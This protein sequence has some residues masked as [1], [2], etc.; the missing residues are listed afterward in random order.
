MFNPYGFRVGRR[1]LILAVITWALSVGDGLVPATS[2]AESLLLTRSA[3]AKS[4]PP[5]SKSAL[6]QA[7]RLLD[8]QEPEAA[9]TMLRRFLS[10]SPRAEDLDDAYLLMAGAMMG[11]KEYGE[12]GKYLTQLLSEFPKSELLPRAKVLLAQTHAQAGNLDLALPL[13]A[14]VR[15]HTDDLNTKREALRLSGDYFV[16]KKDYLRALQVW[17][18]ETRLETDEHPKEAE[19]RIKDLVTQTLDR[20]TLMRV[21]DIYARSFPGDLALMKLIE[22]QTATGEDHLVE[23]NTR[24]FLSRFPNHP[25]VPKASEILSTVKTKFQMYRFV[26]AAVFPLSGKLA[27]FGTDVLNGMQLALEKAREA[28]DTPSIG[29]LVKDSEADHAMFLNDLDELLQHERPLALI[30]PLLSKN[31]PVLAE[32]AEKTRTPVISPSATLPN[33]RRLGTY[34]YSTSLTYAHQARGAAE[35]AVGRQGYKRFCILY[36]DTLY[37]R[38]LARLFAQEV[39]QRD[40]EIIAMDVYKEGASDFALQI[41]NLKAEDLKKYGVEAPPEED[42][43][44]PLSKGA[45][46]SLKR[47]VYTPGFDAVYIPGRAIEV[48]LIASQLAF[49]DIKVPL[50]GANGWNT[51]EFAQVTDR[52]VEGGVFVDGFFVDSPYPNVQDFVSRYQRRF[53]S[54]PS[55]FAAQGYDAARL[56]IEAVRNGASS[57]EGVRDYLLIQRSLPTL[58]GPT[59]FSP[60]GTLNRRVFVIQVQQ[61]KFVQVE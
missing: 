46:K 4:T 43:I 20:K 37:G 18:E 55:L 16:R 58:G 36:P 50:I 7:K 17:L 1:F 42:P 24:L 5:P 13:L 21:R 12:A 32:M 15:S 56:V 60:E 10:G 26:I 45:S 49:Y 39:R 40:G 30:G 53:Q 54:K 41:K 59:G 23:R 14:D 3:L 28:Q 47:V 34:V 48:A 33:V 22:M 2:P 8:A 38:E 44:K 9:A 6:E 27:P 11:M 51:S 61:G 29:L 57:G 31:L 35:Y 19:Q 25:F 52:F